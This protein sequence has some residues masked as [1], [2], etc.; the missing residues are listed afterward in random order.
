MYSHIH[1]HIRIFVSTTNL[2][3]TP[4]QDYLCVFIDIYIYIYICL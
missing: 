2:N 1:S 3:D 4:V